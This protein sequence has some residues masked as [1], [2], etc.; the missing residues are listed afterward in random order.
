M[1]NA[2]TTI[3]DT[4]A[5]RRKKLKYDRITDEISIK[6]YAYEMKQQLYLNGSNN[7]IELGANSQMAYKGNKRL[8]CFHFTPVKIL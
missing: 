4:A 5:L 7:R 8:T 3:F 1:R 2:C 6:K